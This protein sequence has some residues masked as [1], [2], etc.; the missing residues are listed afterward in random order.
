MHHTNNGDSTQQIQTKNPLAI[1]FNSKHQII[2]NE[3]RAQKYKKKR[4][5]Q[6]VINSVEKKIFTNQLSIRKKCIFA[7]RN[8]RIK[9]T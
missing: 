9:R 4:R 8:F 2:L 3:F 7:A 1:N 6:S 5:V